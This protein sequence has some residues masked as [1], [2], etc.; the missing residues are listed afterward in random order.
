MNKETVEIAAE[1]Y[2]QGNTLE[3]AYMQEIP[4]FIA[5]AAWQKE[6][7]FTLEQMI[8]AITYGFEYHR[9]S[10]HNNQDVPNGNKLQWILGK[11]MPPEKHEDFII[12]FGDT[13]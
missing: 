8:E 5:G 11:Y 13:K 1:Q 2:A 12:R 6:Q 3:Y 9:D 10:M 4:A 7:S